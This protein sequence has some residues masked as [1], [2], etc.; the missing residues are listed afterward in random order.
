MF[1]MFLWVASVSPLTG[2]N[3]G[4]NPILMPIY[5][6]ILA[7][8]HIRYCKY[9]Y[10]PL[11]IFVSIFLAWLML[12]SIKNGNYQGTKFIPIYSILIAHVAINIYDKEEFLY[13]F[14][15]ILLFFSC[16]SI[17]VWIIVNIVG[18]PMVM[19]MRSISVV[20]P[21]SPTDSYCFFTGVCAHIEMGIRRNLGFTWE[22]GKYACWL[23]FGMY[24]NLIR[25]RFSIFPIKTNK[26][27]YL[28]LFSLLTTMSTTGYT[29][30]FVI[31][32]FYFYNNN[33]NIQRIAVILLC[34]IIIP[35]LFSL[36]FMWE[37]IFALSDIENGV[38]AIE[39]Y[40]REGQEVICPQRFTGLYVSYN[41]F[42]HDFFL[43]YNNLE[44]S[45]FTKYTMNGQALVDPSEGILRIFAKYGIF[46]GLLYYVTLIKSTVFIS[47]LYQYRGK[48]LF[49]IFFLLIS[50]SY[51][52]WDN[53]I[54]MYFYLSDFYNKCDSR[55]FS[56]FNEL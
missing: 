17:V 27:F 53:C 6:I 23:L 48:Y 14:E 31:I 34:A 20:N 25:N 56:N 16:V 24:I 33:S 8:Y 22:P 44:N 55:Y 5:C 10:K 50:F 12:N 45:F 54:F 18:Q 38:G 40:T 37:K 29:G 35:L 36:P 47:N 49:M 46:V 32:L 2:F 42:I 1:M 13:Y 21:G 15:R 28:F 39:Y 9:L 4:L 7:Y 51:D 3:I 26:I 11:I 30:L 41:N 52:F 43:G 19:L